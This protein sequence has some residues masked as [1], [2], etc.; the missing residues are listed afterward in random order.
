[1]ILIENVMPAAVV[2]K[3]AITTKRLMVGESRPSENCFTEG[4][5][6]YS[7]NTPKFKYCSTDLDCKDVKKS[8]NW[9]YPICM[10]LQPKSQFANGDKGICCNKNGD[11]QTVLSDE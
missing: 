5:S 10:D 7:W 8:L 11:H 1:M 2:V 9:V 3:S 4:N 6:G